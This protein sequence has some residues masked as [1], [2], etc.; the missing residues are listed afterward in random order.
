[1]AEPINADKVLSVAIDMENTGKTFYEALAHGCGKPDMAKLCIRLAREETKH[2]AVFSRMLNQLSKGDRTMPLDD[3]Q[4]EQFHLAIKDAVIPRPQKVRD[5]VLHGGI[6]D[7]LAM[8]AR[9]EQDSIRY[10]EN[11]LR[12]IQPEQ[13]SAVNLIIS[14]ERKHLADLRAQM[15]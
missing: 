8:A 11:V 14:E 13:A 10:Y 3:D 15:V 6:G 1:M 4:A 7:A 2:A 12:P 5:V 9:M